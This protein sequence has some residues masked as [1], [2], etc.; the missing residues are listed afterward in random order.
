MSG[1]NSQTSVK[2]TRKRPIS[3]K[4]P[5]FLRLSC[6]AFVSSYENS[7]TSPK[8]HKSRCAGVVL[9]SICLPQSIARN[10]QRNRKELAKAS[11]DKRKTARSLL[12]IGRLQV[13]LTPVCEF[14]FAVAILSQNFPSAPSPPGR[15]KPLPYADIFAQILPL[16]TYF[17]QN[18]H[19]FVKILPLR[20]HFGPNP[21]LTRIL[22]LKSFPRSKIPYI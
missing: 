20:A 2:I 1:K 7:Q 9:V 18:A 3:N 14:F 19:I 13:I 16:R 17:R 21:S 15:P 4:E 5:A 6:D 12:E 10:S 22:S 8:M 11:Q